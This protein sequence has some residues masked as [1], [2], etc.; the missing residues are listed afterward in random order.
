MATKSLHA[1]SE[2]KEEEVAYFKHKRKILSLKEMM[3][4]EYYSAEK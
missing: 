1:T 4:E 2:R 3:M